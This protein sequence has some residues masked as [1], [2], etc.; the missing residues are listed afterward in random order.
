MSY[1]AA[2]TNESDP[3]NVAEA[4]R[5]PKR[6]LWKKAMHEEYDS[7]IENKTWIPAKTCRGTENIRYKMGVQ[8]EA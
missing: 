7:L 4:I 2:E 8:N 6:K 1:L 3:E 5:G